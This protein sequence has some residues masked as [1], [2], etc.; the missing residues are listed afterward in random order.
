MSIY[1]KNGDTG[2]TSLYSG[3][4]FSK[5]DHVFD[6]LG[7]LDELNA[8]LGMVKAPRIKEINE[9]VHSMQQELFEVGTYIAD[10]RRTTEA[11]DFLKKRTADFEQHI[12]LLDRELPP[13]KNFILPGGS[14][15]ASALHLSRSI[16]RRL[17]R[18][19][20]GYLEKEGL[21]EKEYRMYFNRLSDLLFVM[22]RY[23]NFR[24]GVKDIVWN[25]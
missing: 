20:V 14:S 25:A 18:S 4:R 22:A 15:T 1:T 13:L 5:S 17:E 10:R 9:L 23:S 6:V 24:A 2:E 16:C 12:D 8:S 19:L 11:Y 7:D 3:G 21:E